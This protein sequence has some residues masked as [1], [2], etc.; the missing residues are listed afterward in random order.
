M[1]A[2]GNATPLSP[3][4]DVSNEWIF[5]SVNTVTGKTMRVDMERLVK[6]L[7]QLLGGGFVTEFL[8]E[9]GPDQHGAGMG[10]GRLIP[11]RWAWVAYRPAVV[12]M[13]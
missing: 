4:D 5:Y 13:R 2:A 3:H 6:R 11:H 9:A 12:A 8:Q 7:D 10:H 1:D